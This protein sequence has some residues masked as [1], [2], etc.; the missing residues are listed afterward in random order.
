MIGGSRGALP[1]TVVGLI[2]LLA[3][4]D[5]GASESAPAF[6]PVL[7]ALV[8]AESYANVEP[9]DPKLQTLVRSTGPRLS[10]IVGR[11][12]ITARGDSGKRQRES[13]SVEQTS[14][15]LSGGYD[16]YRR[17][18]LATWLEGGI[19][20]TYLDVRTAPA[21]GQEVRA[22]HT[23]TWADVAGGFDHLFRWL[24]GGTAGPVVGLRIGYRWQI[25][26]S[27]DMDGA[28]AL[29]IS[30][31]YVELSIGFGSWSPDDD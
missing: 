8:L 28:D 10:V 15:A 3:P 29:D 17:Q 6:P 4:M 18:G 21:Q 12:R 9:V 27:V 1:A 23:A 26:H 7:F 24:E 13:T 11:A 5:C 16:F 20:V 2:A 25:E 14:V 19:G 22:R 30:G 31:G